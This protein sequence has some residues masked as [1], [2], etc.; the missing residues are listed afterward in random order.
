MSIFRE[1]FPA[2]VQNELG[3]RQKGMLSRDSAFLHQLN[4][5]SAWVRM[6]SGVNFNGS[7][8]L[9]KNYVMQGGV[10]NYS[11][12]QTKDGNEDIFTQK[13]GLGTS[14][15]TYSNVSYG[16]ST[17]RT[18]IRPMPGITNVSIQSKGAYGSL[19]EATVSFVCWDIK[20]LEEL[21]VLYMRPGYT[22]LL[23]FGWDFA[24]TSNGVLPNYD[25]LNKS[26]IVLNDA[27]AEIYK[28]IDQSNGTYDALLGYV[29]NYNWSARDDGGYDCTTSI[30]SLGEVLESLKCN[31]VPSE[32][33]AFN[34][35]GKGIL[36]LPGNSTDQV[37]ESYEKGIIPGLLQ[38]LWNSMKGKG[39]GSTNVVQ[40]GTTNNYYYLYKLIIDDEKNNRGG[41]EKPLGPKS[42]AEIFITLGS[43]CDLLSTYVLP[44]GAKNKPLSEVITYETDYNSSTYIKYSKTN[45]TN[46]PESLFNSQPT[47]NA[48]ATSLKCIASPLALSTN[49]GVCFVKNDNWD[50][51]E[52]QTPPT[53]TSTI[54]TPDIPADIQVAVDTGFFGF[55][56]PNENYPNNVYKRFASKIDKN[57]VKK[58]GFFNDELWYNYSGNLEQDFQT[59]ATDLLNAIQT[60]NIKETSVTVSNTNTSTTSTNTVLTYDIVFKGG[61]TYSWDSKG[62]VNSIDL[63]TLFGYTDGFKIKPERV[64][65]ELFEYMYNEDGTV[66]YDS[67]VI[68]FRNEDPFDDGDY[69]T[70]EA[71]V[72][73]PKSWSRQQVIALIQKTLSNVALDNR[74]QQILRLNTP[75]VAEQIAQTASKINDKN[76]LP[77]LVP[78]TNDAK[79][80]GYISNIYVN[81][82]YLYEQAISKNSA[83][84]DNQ[85]KN[86]ISVRNYLQT[87][88]RDV[89]NS[90]GN[91]NSFDIQ[92][93]N[94]NAIGRIIDINFTGSPTQN[95]FTLQIHNL[96]SAVRNYKF[97]SKIF[98]E[99]GSIIAISAQDATGIGKLGYDNATLVAWNEGISDRLIPKKD[100]N[101]DIALDKLN[102]PA[103]F[104]LPFL[105]KLYEYFQYINGNNKNNANK[106]NKDNFNYAYGGLDFA[107]RDFLSALDRFDPQNKFKTIIPTELTVILDG[108]GGIIIGNLFKINQ[109]IVPKGYKNVPGRDIAYIV[110][111]IGHQISDND[112]T[113]E[114][115]A[116][117]I[118]FD[119]AP[120]TKVWKQWKNNQYPGTVISAGGRIIPVGGPSQ[121]RSGGT[122]AIPPAVTAASTTQKQVDAMDAALEA[123]FGLNPGA[124]GLCARYTYT[125]GTEYAKALKGKALSGKLITGSGNADSA[126]YRNALTKLGYK[127][128]Y[129][130]SLTKQQVISKIDKGP[131]NVG[132]II[133]YYDP[134]N[135]TDIRHTQI[136]T[137]G[138]S[139]YSGGYLWASSYSDNYTYNFIYNS[140]TDDKDKFQFF[141]YTLN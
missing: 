110:T 48:F 126:S 133:I 27:F 99:M 79:Q 77:F 28:L 69:I 86:T 103:S 35:S 7:S 123:V 10:L 116:Y 52:V 36:Q 82:N 47:L 108:I 60:I 58:P 117:P 61:K 25:I 124:E 50:N 33:I 85:N 64:Y 73:N 115:N 76:A 81:L 98:P 134:S 29:K 136:Y 43:F 83:A 100:F 55:S 91:V 121:G 12:K 140:S 40:D 32:T 87:I 118:V 68:G 13:A 23:E 63:L 56:T 66:S 119:K 5:R 8:T 1:T 49:L 129:N 15:N 112:W 22:I 135:P 24:R 90:L 89:Q 88:L 21:E 127:Q 14:S 106:Q 19:Q 72:P 97:S 94:R 84:N 75:V 95:L 139:P 16:G 141:V 71:F 114:L 93:D 78:S 102:E 17:H 132:D 54:A 130:S 41:L 125:I 4:S 11:V 109:D 137:G 46:L 113:T 101:K 3:R 26:E 80:L 2:F 59:L 30:I 38:E 65:S 138:S 120:S 42:K 128:T 37:I 53:P 44:K 6:T 96:N 57:I 107:Y 45:S 74:L 105:T 67:S 122:G 34:G 70:K 104:L 51:L 62:N 31:W 18:G 9:A 92:V 20:Q 39:N 131:W 111:K